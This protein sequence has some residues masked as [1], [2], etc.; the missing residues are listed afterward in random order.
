MPKTKGFILGIAKTKGFSEK[1]KLLKQE[2]KNKNKTKTKGQSATPFSQ[3]GIV[4]NRKFS[5]VMYQE[6]QIL[7]NLVLLLW[8]FMKTFEFLNAMNEVHML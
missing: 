8:L 5:T 2:S 4:W 1:Q 3:Y 6:I 7:Y